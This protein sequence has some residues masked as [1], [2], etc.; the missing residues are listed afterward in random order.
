MESDLMIY[1]YASIISKSINSGKIANFV[2]Q[3]SHFL[4][5][6]DRD[7]TVPMGEKALAI[8]AATRSKAIDFIILYGYIYM[9]RSTM[10]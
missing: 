4:T 7:L 1:T 5:Y 2:C 3:K 6:E 8:V 10:K 9:V